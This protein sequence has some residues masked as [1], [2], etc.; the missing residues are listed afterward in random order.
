MNYIGIALLV[1]MFLWFIFGIVK[2]K[3]YERGIKERL[4]RFI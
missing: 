1:L 4:G 3:Q 2:I